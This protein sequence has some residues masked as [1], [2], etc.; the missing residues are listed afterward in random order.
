MKFGV[1]FHLIAVFIICLFM[2]SCI[3]PVITLSKETTGSQ[4]TRGTRQTETLN[5]VRVFFHRNNIMNTT[6]NEINLPAAQSA[7]NDGEEIN[8]ELD[9]ELFN[10]LE[11]QGRNFG[12]KYGYKINLLIT[13]VGNEDAD[14]TFKILDDDQLIATG[15]CH[16]S[17]NTDNA[18]EHEISFVDAGKQSHIFTDGSI[19]NVNI[20]ASIAPGTVPQSVIIS[21]EN[22]FNEGYLLLECSQ[23]IKRSVAAY[24]SDGSAGDFYPNHPVEEQRLIRFKGS[25]TDTFGAY[26][27]KSVLIDF[28]TV[29]DEPQEA[30][31]AIDPADEAIGRFVLEYTY[32]TGLTPT[33]YT[34]TADIIDNSNNHHSAQSSLIMSDYGVFLECEEPYGEGL[35]GKIVSFDIDIYNVGGQSDIISMD[36]ETEGPSGWTASFISGDNT[37]MI[38]PGEFEI[39]TLDVTVSP[40]A[41]GNEKC[42]IQVTGSSTNDNVI[43]KESY[44]LTPPL[45]AVAISVFDFDFINI[46]SLQKNVSDTG[47]SVEYEFNLKNKGQEKD[48]YTVVGDAPATGSGWGASLTTTHPDANPVPELGYNIELDAD[49]DAT[50]TFTVT[51]PSNPDEETMVLDVKATGTN[52]TETI[53]RTT[54]TKIMGKPGIVTISTDNNKQIADPGEAI[55]QNGTMVVEFDLE[56]D[57]EDQINAYS[58]DLEINDLETGWDYSISPNN[59]NLDPEENERISLTLEIPE[60]ETADD[61]LITVIGGY[62]TNQETNIEL[63]V[64]IVQVV[65]VFLET[66]EN[67]MTVEAGEQAVFQVYVINKGNVVNTIELTITELDDWDVD[68]SNPSITLDK[69]DSK[70]KVTITITPSTSVEADE[71]GIFDIKIKDSVESN[72]LTLKVTVKKDINTQLSNFLIDYWFIPILVIII[73][74][75]TFIIRS[76]M[77]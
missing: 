5:E 7:L 29:F 55:D 3:I 17:G 57:N 27:I 74:I 52:V 25:V 18:Q 15:I 43:P 61:Y 21:Y 14:I 62:G 9:R 59:F 6:P 22:G 46:G 24:H 23:V 12:T 19:I 2:V 36:V 26:D 47:G 10:D 45:E 48:I 49:S 38:A 31:Y 13:K 68:I 33:T 44:D 28:E 35:P 63:S 42:V 58:V 8:F 32:G 40:D 72:K 69:Y 67:E 37:A 77:K 54:T 70:V 39:K 64:T 60:T 1:A 30:T 53:T 34:V 75:L 11:V 73:F 16:L 41:L 66:A 65:E 76:R 71:N 50:F 56:V 20:N 51:A 4:N